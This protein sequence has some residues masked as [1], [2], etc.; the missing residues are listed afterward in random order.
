MH[1]RTAVGV[2]AVVAVVALSIAPAVAQDDGG[3][4][5]C[6][7]SLRECFELFNDCL[8]M[9]LIVESL[10]PAA[11]QIGLTD[12]RLQ[13]LAESRL[14]AARIYTEDRPWTPYLYI[15]VNVGGA[16]ARAFSVSLQY[17][18]VL[19]HLRTGTDGY[20]TT[21]STGA[22]GTHGQDGGYILQAVSEYLDE[23]VLAYL[24]IN[25]PACES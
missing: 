6:S 16:R 8:P 23:F 10:P 2:V 19:D 21:W 18:K 14:R 12:S 1:T 15:N 22:V 13:T 25:E 9:E 3:D 11:G 4:S 7:A 24:R 5:Q 20:G 17:K